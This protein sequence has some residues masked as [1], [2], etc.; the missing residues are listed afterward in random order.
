MLPPKRLWIPAPIVPTIERER[1][2]I[3]RTMP[4]LRLIRKPGRSW[5]DVVNARSIMG[6]RLREGLARLL[7]NELRLET[8]QR[9]LVALRA[10]EAR[11]D[12]GAVA[13]GHARDDEQADSRA[14]RKGDQGK[15][16]EG[17]G[18]VPGPEALPPE[19]IAHERVR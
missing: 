9:V 2:T 13:R 3:P 15:R 19:V 10:P 16:G 18:E 14:D 8:D 11:E 5:A 6:G 17:E 7:R 4:R 12:A 1:T